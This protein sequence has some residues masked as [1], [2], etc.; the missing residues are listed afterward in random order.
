M[1]GWVDRIATFQK[2]VQANAKSRRQTPCFRKYD[3]FHGK[4]HIDF[5]A[6]RASFEW[7]LSCHSCYLV[8][9]DKAATTEKRPSLAA[10]L[11]IP[12]YRVSTMTHIPSLNILIFFAPSLAHLTPCKYPLPTWTLFSRKR[13]LHG[14]WLM[15]RSA[16][17][18]AKRHVV[19]Q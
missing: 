14:T 9:F 3:T 6:F 19:T 2:H 1:F 10:Q 16:I 12:N 11:F 15:A 7:H 4:G 18:L 17:P 13:I 5:C 8:L